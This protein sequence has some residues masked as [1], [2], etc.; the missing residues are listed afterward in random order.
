MTIIACEADCAELAV[1]TEAG[2]QP[3]VFAHGWQCSDAP[4]DARPSTLGP[5]HRG[6]G[7]RVCGVC[8]ERAGGIDGPLAAH[9]RL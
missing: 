6:G 5:A 4:D 3:K 8:V 9:H 1:A 2:W 7:R